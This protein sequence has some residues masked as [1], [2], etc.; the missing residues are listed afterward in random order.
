MRL[1]F[2]K[3]AYAAGVLLALA[4]TFSCTSDIE[5]PP[6]LPDYSSSAEDTGSSS[7]SSSSSSSLSVSAVWCVV[8]ENCVSI[9]PETCTILGGQQVQ[10][11]PA[12]SSSSIAL[13]SSSS[14]SVIPSS[15][16]VVPIVPSSSSVPLSSSSS[17]PSS[18]SIALPS[19]NSVG[20]GLCDGFVN[21][22]MREHYGKE[23]EQF[24]DERDGKKYVY[25]TIGGQVWMAENLNYNANGSKC[26][27][28]LES[29]CETYGRLYNWA[30]AMTLDISCNSN[31]CSGQV[32]AKHR[33][34]CPNGWHIPSDAEWTTLITLAGGQYNAGTKLKAT[35]WS[36]QSQSTDNYGFAAL[37]GG[38][39][40][41]DGNFASNFGSWLSAS[42]IGTSANVFG[43]DYSYTFFG[44]ENKNVLRSVRCVKD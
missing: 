8:G 25:V 24:C 30:T 12:A 44:S 14:S 33:G 28:N 17:T 3:F 41:T 18:S 16:S 31:N 19:S 35:N 7:S 1:Q 23:K 20:T 27:S 43:M 15:S 5:L 2:S 13:P 42:E 39:G 26:N 21:G 29:N 34:I 11:C 9:A 4:L 38:Q 22:T 40:T 36:S 6:P 32:S 10:S 37:P